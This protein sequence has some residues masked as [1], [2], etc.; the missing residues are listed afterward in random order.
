MSDITI[1]EEEYKELLDYKKY[2]N[3]LH[4]L[5]NKKGKAY[6]KYREY[7]EKEAFFKRTFG[8]VYA[9]MERNYVE[10]KRIINNIH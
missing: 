1:T 8:E 6:D 3:V 2:F 5:K 7:E 4:Q 10:Q 9:N